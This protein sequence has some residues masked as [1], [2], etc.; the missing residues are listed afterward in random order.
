M[1]LGLNPSTQTAVVKPTMAKPTMYV[2]TFTH[3]GI[4][5]SYTIEVSKMVVPT[6][7]SWIEPIED[8]PKFPNGGTYTGKILSSS[9]EEAQQIM[10]DLIAELKKTSP[11]VQP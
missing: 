7:K 6:K 3:N 8:H 2:Y 10:F 11:L 9:R 5:D 1:F 4:V